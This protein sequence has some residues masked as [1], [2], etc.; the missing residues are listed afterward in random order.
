MVSDV[1]QRIIERAVLARGVDTR[2]LD[3][4]SE[5]R[6]FGTVHTCIGQEFT[7]ATLAEW[8][9]PGDTL[10]STHRCHGHFLSWVGDAEGLIAELM[11]RVTGVCR[12]IGGSQH[13]HAPGFFSSGI[14]G[15]TMPVAA[16]M[17]L[18]AQLGGTSQLAVAFIGDGTLG[19]G[20]V[21]ET[22]NL[23]SLWKLPVLIV[24][25]DNGYAQS[26]PKSQN[27][28]GSIDARFEAFGVPV[29]RANT[30]DWAGLY[31]VFGDAS[32]AV[33]SGGGP[34]CVVID[35]YRLKAHSKGDDL[36][37]LDEL[38][39]FRVRDPITML[40]VA[41]DEDALRAIAVAGARITR[42][43]DVASTAAYPEPLPMVSSAAA[44]WT[45]AELPRTRVLSA[46]NG[47]LRRAL[48]TDPKVVVIGEDIEGVY[49]GAFKATDGLSLAHPGRVRNTPISEA[50]IVGTGTGLAMAGYRP[51]VE[52]M[53]GDFSLLAF[54][55][56]VNHAAKFERM[57]RLETPVN[58]IVRT[59]MGGG[60]GYGPTHS[61]SLEKHFLGVPGLRVAAISTL[62]DPGVVYDALLSDDRG[63][64]LVIEHK[65]S[66][67]AMLRAELPDGFSL[68]HSDDL[69]PAAWVRPATTHVD[70]T[71]LGYGGMS[72]V[73]VEAADRLFE[74]H[75]I[76]AQVLCLSEL[77]PAEMTRYREV[78]AA[79]HAVVVVEEGQ[80]FAG[81]G[82]EMSAQIT[83]MVPD[84][85]KRFSR[86]A[87]LPDVI[88]SSGPLEKQI[89][90]G[91]NAVCRAVREVLA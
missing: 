70:V 53:F 83:Q 10:F 32:K 28:A 59:P 1:R 61:Q 24:L 77:Y 22:L 7:G 89:L 72:D 9:Q 34:A 86:V 75:D 58:L 85:A 62:V 64:S 29:Y 16:G 13:L 15:G 79:A 45:P 52:I 87:S 69:V 84:L 30:W 44:Q 41:Q 27:L 40:E 19:E 71:I 76:V 88:P 68:W 73:M 49:G 12:G 3:L 14:Q 33:R 46:L 47:A 37:A 26:T 56:L 25:E 67:A 50:C 17:A 66:Y 2:L 35:T 55:Q 36:R 51:V 57:Y 6:L 39:A 90:P 42:A 43:V 21:Y 20:L 4:F 18:G 91:V 63:V 31:D 23:A 11:G 80:G 5:G 60:R 74:D 81:F 65:T 54:D 8:L 82:A 38:E 78:F 48:D